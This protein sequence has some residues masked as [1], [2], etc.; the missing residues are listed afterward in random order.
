MLR[1]LPGIRLKLVLVRWN[2]LGEHLPISHL[3]DPSIFGMDP[4]NSIFGFGST[5]GPSRVSASVPKWGATMHMY[6][7]IEM[8]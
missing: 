8:Q 4:P 2:P 5:S 3:F 1:G 6:E 7:Y